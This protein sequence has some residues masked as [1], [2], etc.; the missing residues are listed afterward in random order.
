MLFVLTMV[1]DNGSRSRSNENGDRELPNGVLGKELPPLS[2]KPK[3][4]ADAR[5]TKSTQME[6]PSSEQLQ[7]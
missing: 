7:S 3:T 2:K 5:K 1:K 4:R 6:V